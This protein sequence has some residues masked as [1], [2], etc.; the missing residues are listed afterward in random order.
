MLKFFLN[1]KLAISIQ[2]YNNYI[3]TFPNKKNYSKLYF[4]TLVLWN[5]DLLWKTMVH[6]KNYGTI[7]KT[8]V[9]Y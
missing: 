7:D 6:G 5:F 3:V 2:F 8:M 1:K 4:K 9:L